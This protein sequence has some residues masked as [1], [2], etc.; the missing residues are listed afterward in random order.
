MNNYKV[1][2]SYIGTRYKGSQYQPNDPTVEKELK[3]ALYK[4]YKKNV[5]ITFAGRTDAGVHS[6]GQVVSY[7]SNLY[8]PAEKLLVAINACLPCDIK[9][10]SVSEVE[11]GFHAR[12]SAVSR[13]YRYLFS[14]QDLPVFLRP[15]VTTVRFKVNLNNIAGIKNIIEGCHDFRHLY[16]KG[17]T[18]GPTVRTIYEFS[19]KKKSLTDIFEVYTDNNLLVYEI[20]IR[21]NSFL[22]RMVR[23][24]VGAIFEILKG[25]QTE[26]DFKELLKIGE[27]PYYYSV[28]PANGL[29]LIKVEY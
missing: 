5:P 19:V 20:K 25:K 29:N 11:S 9:V 26:A 17:S 24:I 6:S 22:Y 12:K 2:L 18:P 15:Y 27:K 13:E 23:C 10:K 1:E 4:I 7:R 21:A 8:I 16:C 14:D 3:D 28:V